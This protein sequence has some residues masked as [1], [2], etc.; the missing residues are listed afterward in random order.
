MMNNIKETL[1]KNKIS[2]SFHRIKVYEYLMNNKTHPS[3]ETI[4][5]ELHSV[6]PT[7]SKT[8][9]YNNLKTFMEHGIV[10]PITITENEV[11][12]DADITFHGHF[13]CTEC[14]EVHDIFNIEKLCSKIDTIEGHRIS[15]TQV[16]FKGICKSCLKGI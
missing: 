3:V 4:Y 12:Y 16:F 13:K 8:T 14:G 5:S 11:R 6:I 1:V 7:L 15:D 9:I 2:P 10:M